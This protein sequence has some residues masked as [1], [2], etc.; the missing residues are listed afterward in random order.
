MKANE[1]KDVPFP[2]CCKECEVLPLLGAGECESVC[3]EKFK[4]GKD[5]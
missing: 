1:L 2:D 4:A 3:P 5:E